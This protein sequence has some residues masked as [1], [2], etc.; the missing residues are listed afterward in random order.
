[1]HT[2]KFEQMQGTMKCLI[3]SIAT[4]RKNKYDIQDQSSSLQDMSNIFYRNARKLQWKTKWDQYNLYILI[5]VL[6][7]WALLFFV[8]HNHMVAYILVSLVIFALLFAVQ[9]FATMCYLA[10][11]ERAIALSE[12]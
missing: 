10:Q 7:V 1:M 11:L 9:H 12:P 4:L 3:E 6:V 2:I 8:F 5:A